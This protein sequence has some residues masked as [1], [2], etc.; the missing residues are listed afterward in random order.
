MNHSSDSCT[1]R[2]CYWLCGFVVDDAVKAEQFIRVD[3]SLHNF[4]VTAPDRSH[5]LRCEH[6]LVTMCLS[7]NASSQIHHFSILLL[8]WQDIGT[9]VRC[10][11]ALV[12]Y[13]ADLSDI[14]ATVCRR[15]P[16]EYHRSE[17]FRTAHLAPTQNQNQRL[18]DSCR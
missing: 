13:S 6:W 3:K 4:F 2:A 9:I 14:A 5:S 7:T 16:A 1:H 15:H 12:Q 10:A 17:T 8:H 11:A 18:S